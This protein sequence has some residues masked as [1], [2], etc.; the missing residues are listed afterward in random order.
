MRHTVPHGT[1]QMLDELMR[2]HEI[3]EVSEAV[4]LLVLN[5]HAEDLPPAAPKVK[6]PSE[7]IATTSARECVTVASA[8]RRTWREKRPRHHMAA[9]R[10]RPF[11]AYREVSA[12]LPN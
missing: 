6:G 11:I 12:T 3:D 10:I 5:G 2:W 8:H 4:Q 9:D 1:Q 7:L